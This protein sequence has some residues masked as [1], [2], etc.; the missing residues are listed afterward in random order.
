MDGQGRSWLKSAGRGHTV[1]VAGKEGGGGKRLGVGVARVGR[2]TSS[3]VNL[4][5]GP[6]EGCLQTQNC[7]KPVLGTPG[8]WRQTISS[9]RPTE[10]ARPPSCYW[11]PARLSSS[12]VRV[13]GPAYLWLRHTSLC[14]SGRRGQTCQGAHLKVRQ[15]TLHCCNETPARLCR[16]P[17]R[18]PPPSSQDSALATSSAGNLCCPGASGGKHRVLQSRTR[19]HRRHTLPGLPLIQHQI[20]KNCGSGSSWART[21]GS[22]QGLLGSPARAGPRGHDGTTGEGSEDC[23]R[24]SGSREQPALSSLV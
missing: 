19:S 2:G 21:D 13:P 14:V 5:L 18:P 12:S 20:K 17:P 15:F 24:D 10:S 16:D 22:V 1:G 6:P 23:G 4:G 3:Q 11:G 8:M 9:G 7:R